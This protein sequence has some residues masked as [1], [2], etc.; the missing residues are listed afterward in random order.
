[1]GEGDALGVRTVSTFL[2]DLVFFSPI[3][4]SPQ[5]QYN[6]LI[7]MHCL[8]PCIAT[9]WI[10]WSVC[11]TID[12][13]HVCGNAANLEDRTIRFFYRRENFFYFVLQIGC[14]PTNVQG[15]YML[16]PLWIAVRVSITD[17]TLAFWLEGSQ[18]KQSNSILN[19]CDQQWCHYQIMMTWSPVSVSVFSHR[20][21][22]NKTWR[23]ERSVNVA[24]Q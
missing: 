2:C 18:L 6:W 12:P 10:H 13:L 17:R 9:T 19:I 23:D 5:V 24:A 21:Q 1:M 14:I 20:R 15:V 7:I 8:F 11:I 16:S 4:W 3:L 22:F